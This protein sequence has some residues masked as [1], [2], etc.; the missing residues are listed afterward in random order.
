MKGLLL[1]TAYLTRMLSLAVRYRLGRKEQTFWDWCF[2]D[3]VSKK[4]RTGECNVH[5]LHFLV[6]DAIEH[7]AAQSLERLM[8]SFHGEIETHFSPEFQGR[9]ANALTGKR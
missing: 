4:E 5:Q 8:Y 9:I 2:Q 3:L 7:G 1:Q 6:G